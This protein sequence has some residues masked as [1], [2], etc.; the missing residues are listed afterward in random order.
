MGAQKG[1]QPPQEGDVG[2]DSWWLGED[3]LLWG[4]DS[5]MT[6][7]LFVFKY[8]NMYMFIYIYFHSVYT[9]LF[10]ECFSSVG[11]H[12]LHFFETFESTRRTLS[13]LNLDSAS[14]GFSSTD[15]GENTKPNNWRNN[16][17]QPKD[18]SLFGICRHKKWFFLNYSCHLFVFF[19][20]LKL[21]SSSK[22]TWCFSKKVF[23]SRVIPSPFIS[24]NT[25]FQNNK[26][27]NGPFF[28]PDP[29]RGHGATR[30][31][32]SCGAVFEAAQLSFLG[33][34]MV[35]SL[36]ESTTEN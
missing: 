20:F 28:V 33:D 30:L 3:I 14:D 9:Y 6:F 10:Y 32:V 12:Y 4:F 22:K 35:E 16:F 11:K 13:N 25:G 7:S 15:R 1:D 21:I 5:L 36:D 27:E 18:V 31:W 29:F 19:M 17:K 23:F 2:D 8:I 34:Q 24:Q 26:N